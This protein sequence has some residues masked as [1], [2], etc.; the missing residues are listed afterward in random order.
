MENTKSA[1]SSHFGSRAAQD[2]LSISFCRHAALFG[3]GARAPRPDRTRAG[4]PTGSRS[5]FSSAVEISASGMGRE[6]SPREHNCS[7]AAGAPAPRAG[8]ARRDGRHH[9]W[10]GSAASAFPCRW[11]RQRDA[12]S[13]ARRLYKRAYA[14]DRKNDA[15]LFMPADRRPRS[16]FA[17]ILPA[18]LLVA[19]PTTH[20]SATA[21]GATIATT[22]CAGA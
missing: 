16:L 4:E 2:Y 15:T 20:R 6:H 10:H 5:A 13:S 12:R 7:G 9:A 3:D 19:A 21:N 8:R 22:R 1:S 14:R 17:G 18:L 11:L